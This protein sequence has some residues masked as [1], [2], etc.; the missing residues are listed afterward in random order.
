VVFRP[1]ILG[2]QYILL[3][4]RFLRFFENLKKCDFL[5]F[6]ALLHMFSGTMSV[7]MALQQT[8]LQKWLKSLIHYYSSLPCVGH[9]HA[10]PATGLLGLQM[11]TA[12]F[13]KT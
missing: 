13:T 9:R 12:M 8:V 6:F 2:L 1:K 10:N 4:L 11:N 5:R 3:F 7:A